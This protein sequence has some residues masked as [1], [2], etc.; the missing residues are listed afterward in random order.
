MSFITSN[1]Y[2]VFEK[3]ND[4]LEKC[5]SAFNSEFPEFLR[6][7]WSS[8][9]EDEIVKIETSDSP[10]DAFNKSINYPSHEGYAELDNL[11]TFGENDS[12]G[13]SDDV[14]RVVGYLYN[15][16]LHE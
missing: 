12:I 3:N 14:L 13:L 2:D 16:H 9:Y 11:F 5:L 10:I 15:I 4:S 8:N 7:R 1:D 6:H